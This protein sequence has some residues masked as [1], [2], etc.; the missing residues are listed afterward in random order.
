MRYRRSLWGPVVAV[1]AMLAAACAVEEATPDPDAAPTTAAEAQPVTTTEA[2]P[3]EEPE[4]APEPEPEPEVEPAPTTSATAEA[5]PAPTTSA[6]PEPEAEEETEAAP[7]PEEEA[8]AA[9]EPEPAAEPESDSEPD[10]DSTT[11]PEPEPEPAEGSIEDDNQIAEVYGRLLPDLMD[12]W[13]IPGGAFAFARHGRLLFAGGYGTA[14]PDTQ[15]PVRPDSLFRIASISKPITAV[16][17]LKLVEEGKLN[18]DDRAFD[19]LTP[20]APVAD[21]R[22][23]DITVRQLLHHSAG[24]DPASSF[25]PMWDPHR[26]AEHLGVPKPVSCAQTVRFMLAQP[27]DFDP[28]ERY[29]Y[30]NFGYCLLG[31]IIEAVAE[32]SYEEYVAEHILRPL[33]LT[34][35]HIGATLASAAAEGEVRYV[36][37]PGQPLAYSAVSDDPETVPWPYGGFNLRAMEAPGGWVASAIDLVRFAMAVDG[38][39]HPAVLSPTTVETMLSPPDLQSGSDQA[40]HY[41]LGWLVRPVGD[42]A[43][44]WHDG[45]LPGTSSLLV[46]TYHGMVWSAV[47]NSRPEEWVT[48][49]S[50]LDALL[51]Q[52]L[53]EIDDWP[54]HDLFAHYGYE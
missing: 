22:L 20:E 19:L 40:Y 41:G 39:K 48:F 15:Q 6:A 18:L 21:P 17:L 44:W 14:D 51:W 1:L 4:A 50:E 53:G 36:G 49:G 7:E 23:R 13:G 3:E 8:E 45:S 12:R 28:G 9:P 2:P 10:S 33:G 16:A 42:E 32:Q 52:G 24:W 34:G 27:L 47:F 25:D 43:T 29:A 26:V 30:S 35:M 46:R 5:E 11:V 38:S 31:L 37:Y 54:S